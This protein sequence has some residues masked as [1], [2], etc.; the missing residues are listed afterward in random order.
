LVLKKMNVVVD[1]T[2]AAASDAAPSTGAA[3][4]ERV[5]RSG[6]ALLFGLCCAVGRRR[7]TV[8]VQIV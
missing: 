4:K 1:P 8:K 2:S 7:W 6:A 3:E 5:R